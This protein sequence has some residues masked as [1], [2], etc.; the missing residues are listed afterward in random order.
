MIG[1]KLRIRTGRL[2]LFR[3]LTIVFWWG[4]VLAD[5][6]ISDLDVIISVKISYL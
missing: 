6:I 1:L 3:P 5:S 4:L 2:R